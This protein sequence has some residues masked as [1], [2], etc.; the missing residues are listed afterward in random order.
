MAMVINTNMGS[1]NAVR[2]LD[3]TSK[4]QST[5]MERLT[6]GLRINRAA[7]DAAGL[8]VAEKMT[9]QIRGTDQAIRNASDGISM[10]QTMDG[11]VEE[12]VNMLQRMRELGVQALNGNYTADNRTQ[13]DTEFDQLKLE[14]D[15]V[16]QTTTFNDQ[17]IL[18]ASAS[19]NSLAQQFHV[20]WDTGNENK[21]SVSALNFGVS[22]LS[23]GGGFVLSNLSLANS[24]S[25][26]SVA[27]SEIDGVLSTIN[28][29][30]ASWGA[31]QNRLESTVSNLSNV[32]EN[33]NAS[34]SR[35]IDADF[36]KESANLAR[37]QVLQQAGMSMLSQANQSSQNVLQ[38]L[39]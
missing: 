29:Q 27:I 6:S 38:L 35:V 16:A 32:N 37:T 24:V 5:S 4:E 20:G 12:I 34:R 13:M 9:T 10:V 17:K 19:S 25:A 1:L 23:G 15:R 31:V 14:I 28:L 3:S 22:A 7:D 11:A 30:R 8:A 21:I 33:M 39:Q 26:A 18:N 2:M 36:A